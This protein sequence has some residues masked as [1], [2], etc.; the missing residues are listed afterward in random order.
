MLASRPL[1]LPAEGRM[2]T[3]TPGRENA[4]HRGAMTGLGKGK[5]HLL[6]AQPHTVQPQRITKDSKNSTRTVARPLGD[7]TPFPNRDDAGKFVTPL[8]GEQ[9]I[10]KLVLLETTLPKFNLLH[11]GTTPDSVARPSSTRKH[12]RAPRSASKNFETPVTTGNHWDVSELDLVIPAVEEPQVP[13]PPEDDYDEIE[14]MPPNS[15]DVPYVPPFDFPLPDYTAVGA[16]LLR[17]AHS[18]PPDET[19][20]PNSEPDLDACTWDMPVFA[21]PDIESDDPFLDA[22]SK[23]Q[24]LTARLGTAAPGRTSARV[25]PALKK[26]IAASR[27]PLPTTLNK[28]LNKAPAPRAPIGAASNK[29]PASAPSNRSGV[30][31]VGAASR[32]PSNKPPMAR[33]APTKPP[34][35]ASTKLS[36]PKDPPMSRRIPPVRAPTQTSA[37]L[38]MAPVV[39]PDPPTEEDFLF[40]I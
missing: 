3:K 24:Q 38:A 36:V 20:P 17:L 37:S 31:L 35:S 40:D 5:Q 8:P 26:P 13:A 39:G 25:V 12:V 19:L 29:L 32:K 7:K 16:S 21:L 27:K 30:P 15:L 1:H 33:V 2:A 28:P 18:Y 23:S 4:V 22:L 34:T 11:P 9:K 6:A 10:A 14:Y